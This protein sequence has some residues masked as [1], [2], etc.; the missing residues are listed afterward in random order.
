MERLDA[1]VT[2]GGAFRFVRIGLSVTQKPIEEVGCYL[3]GSGWPLPAIVDVG[4]SRAIDLAIEVPC[5]T[6]DLGTMTTHKM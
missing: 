2:V 3:V 5:R 4:H 6:S 1:L